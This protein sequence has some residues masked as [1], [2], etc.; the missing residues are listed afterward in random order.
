MHIFAPLFSD[1]H[2]D[3]EHIM[4]RSL[5]AIMPLLLALTFSCVKYPLPNYPQ[6][7]PV[8]KEEQGTDPE[9][10]KEPEQGQDPEQPQEP[11]K[12][13]EV[14]TM[15][16]D[17]E[18][19]VVRD[20]IDYVYEHPYTDTDFTATYIENYYRT[21]RNNGFRGDWPAVKSIGWEI[22]QGSTSQTVVIS[23]K[24]DGSD[25]IQTVTLPADTGSYTVTD[26]IPGHTYY[27]T[28][29]AQIGDGGSEDE[30]KAVIN[31][32][33]RRRMIAVDGIGNVRDLGGLC[34]EDGKHVKYG[35]LFR[36]SRLNNNGMTLSQ[37]DKDELLRIGIRADL[38][39]REDTSDKL[40]SV[41]GVYR[42]PISNDI[43]Y[44]LFPLANKSYFD[45]LRVNDEYIKA[46]QWVIDEL[47]DGKPV[48]FHC[49]TGADRTGTLAFL[50]E[51]LLGVTEMD[52]SID[53]ELT[54]FF[55]D[56]GDPQSYAFRSRNI[57]K[58]IEI[59]D[60]SAYNWEEMHK[61]LDSYYSGSSFQ[62]K[63]YNYFLKGIGKFTS[64]K[65]SSED[66]DWFIDCML[67]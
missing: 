14:V 18:N 3:T 46:M 26:L 16:F 61:L 30:Y 62:Q 7:T 33:G 60:K 59:A 58:T 50:I 37:G 15:D 38:D 25:P 44:E 53:F 67:E 57:N 1:T 56:F 22:V 51:S 52:K 27:C 9:P 47:R 32:T 8:E 34:T 21:P 29:S 49:K 63:V 13:I 36:G 31:A 40:G 10:D 19:E 23:E 24:E 66:L 11:E 55:Y 5:Y 20:Y 4:K 35:L 12:T 41:Y 42:S 43:D 39:L 28:V 65:I 17:L 6:K 48:Y 45:K 64:S 2:N 54:S